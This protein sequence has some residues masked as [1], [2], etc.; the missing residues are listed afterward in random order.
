[1]FVDRTENQ[2]N[3]KVS[4]EAEWT[5]KAEIKVPIAENPH[6]LIFYFFLKPGVIHR[7]ETLISASTAGHRETYPDPSSRNS[8]GHPV[9][10]SSTCCQDRSCT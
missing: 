5:M 9:N 7:A 4:S 8:G 3:G 2:E 10:K 1:M 6:L